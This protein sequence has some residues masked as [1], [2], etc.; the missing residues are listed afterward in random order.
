MDYNVMDSL[1]CPLT[2]TIFTGVITNRSL[3]L[4]IWYQ[5]EKVVQAGDVLTPQQ[6]QIAIN[7]VA[8]DMA[9]ITVFPFNR[10]NWKLLSRRTL[11]PANGVE[12][13][14]ACTRQ[15]QCRF[16][17]CPYGLKKTRQLNG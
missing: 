1:V 10:E 8:S 4:I 9:I 5:G 11:C 12:K 7:G 3:K 14:L 2:G 13:P 6:Q 15:E 17:A 16:A